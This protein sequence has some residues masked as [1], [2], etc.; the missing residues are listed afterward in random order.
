MPKIEK[1]PIIL[2]TGFLGSGKTTLLSR[3]LH[4]PE[5][6]G[7]MV[8]VNE[9]GEVGLD[10]RL[11]TTSTDVPLLLDTGCACCA[12]Q[13]DLVGTLERLFWDRLHKRIARFSWV[14]IETTG[15]ADPLPIIDGIRRHVLLN[16]RYVI[17]GVVTALDAVSGL[18]RLPDFPEC[19]NQ[20][21]AAN[22]VIITKTDIANPQMIADARAQLGTHSPHAQVLES[23]G[24]DLPAQS[25]LDAL[26]KCP[27]CGAHGHG[28]EHHDHAHDHGDGNHVHAEH[29]ANVSSAFL[30]LGGSQSWPVLIA[31]LDTAMEG[32]GR[33]LLRLK[34]IVKLDGAPGYYAVQATPG[35]GITRTEIPVEPGEQPRTGFT[36]ISAGDPAA[37]LASSLQALIAVKA[38]WADARGVGGAASRESVQ[39]TTRQQS[40]ASRVGSAGDA[41]SNDARDEKNLEPSRRSMES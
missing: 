2:L 15:I 7:A 11:L 14:L 27:D 22:V 38:A 18:S 36:L 31:A 9:Y 28:H 24:G 41:Q 37:G 17:A 19:R 33:S 8:I 1:I 23:A 40:D 20:L 12:A 39:G 5:F 25:L 35:Q 16:E 4:A 32:Y 10:H 21:A 29:A 26:D 34:G 6:A 3:W 30:P 13:E